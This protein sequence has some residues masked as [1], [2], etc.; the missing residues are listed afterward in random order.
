MV[1]RRFR[2]E[3]ITEA[4][5]KRNVIWLSGVRRAGKSFLSQSRQQKVSKNKF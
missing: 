4:W 3:K 2:V 5:Q 1:K